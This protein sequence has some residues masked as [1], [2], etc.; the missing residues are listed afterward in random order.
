MMKIGAFAL[1]GFLALS[2][3]ARAAD[4]PAFVNATVC[5]AAAPITAATAVFRRHVS[6]RIS[7]HPRVAQRPAPR[8]AQRAAATK[9]ATAQPQRQAA[10]SAP[11]HVQ[12]AE[13]PIA[14]NE[15]VLR[16]AV[17][18]CVTP[19]GWENPVRYT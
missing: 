10:R 17:H 14:E 9:R 5:D 18:F 3:S 6:A 2:A 1:F 8:P 15:A 12:E 19:A 4:T 11:R 7:A 16:P 13:A